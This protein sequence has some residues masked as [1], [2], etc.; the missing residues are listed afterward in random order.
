M[1]RRK[2]STVH[3]ALV[4]VQLQFAVHY[5]AAKVLLREIPAGAWAVLR[6]LPAAALFLALGAKVGI[7]RLRGR[8]LAELGM[9]AFFGVVLNQVMFIQGLSRTTPAHSALINTTIPI[10]TI[11]FA[12]LLGRESWRPLRAFG[13]AISLCGVLVLLKVDQLQMRAEWFVGDLM[14]LVNA[15]S[16][17]LFL[18]LSK[19]GVARWGPI[20]ATAGFLAFGSVGIA[21][22]GAGDLAHF[23]L[24]T[25]SAKTWWIAA[26]IILGPTG[27]TYFLNSW[28][29]T[30]VE[31][32]QVALFVYLQPVIAAAL[33]AA[34]LGE[35]I[36]GRFVASALLVFCG[37]YFATRPKAG[38]E[39][40]GRAP[41]AATER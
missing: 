14:T 10:A 33:S 37:V 25:V 38:S 9:Y 17:G 23:D 13:V 39:T 26:F 24:A 29:L 28:A 15:A 4:A 16:F 32:S 1:T 18:V 19:R 3:V 27:A 5:L 11:L 6:I 30:R 7:P 31:S 35:P 40:G 2:I 36:T 22:A 21:L 12:T 20:P 41:V 8:D 34:F